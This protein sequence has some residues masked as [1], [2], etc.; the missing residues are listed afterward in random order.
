MTYYWT[1][2]SGNNYYNYTGSD[3]LHADG[4]GGNDTI[5]GNNG[6]DTISGGAGNDY[7]YGRNGNDY[8]LGGSGHDHLYGGDGN[9]RLD[10]YP[11]SG[12][13][14]DTLSGGAG[15]DTFVLG[16]SWGVSYP[17][18]GYATITD[19]NGQYDW[20]EVRGSSSNYSLSYS[21][22]SGGSATD[23][24]LYYGNDLIAVIQDTTNVQWSR[25]FQWV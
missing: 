9:D 14:S 10:G 23:T 2:T 11:T 3:K 13:E 19:F 5:W 12:T 24:L 22:W 21:S 8:L 15:F 17:G 4:L 6:N 20:L 1:G 16:G 7:L 18:S 25:D